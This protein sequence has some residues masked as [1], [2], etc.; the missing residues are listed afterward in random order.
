MSLP[1]PAFPEVPC[2]EI[3]FDFVF[4]DPDDR[5]FPV[6]FPK[7]AWVDS[8]APVPPSKGRRTEHVLGEKP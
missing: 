3:P 5:A 4:L 2:P 6:L 1:T 8:S 7:A